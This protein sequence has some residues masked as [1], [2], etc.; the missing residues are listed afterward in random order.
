M[1][2]SSAKRLAMAIGS[3]SCLLLLAW[4]IGEA[5]ALRAAKEPRELVGQR[6][7][8]SRN[9]LNEYLRD[10]QGRAVM[11]DPSTDLPRWRQYAIQYGLNLVGVELTVDKRM[12]L[13]DLPLKKP[14]LKLSFADGAKSEIGLGLFR[15]IDSRP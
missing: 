4:G 9:I 12:S 10:N 3:L 5:F 1:A 11:S 2:N 8:L 13:E 6:E 7:V 14:V 15:D